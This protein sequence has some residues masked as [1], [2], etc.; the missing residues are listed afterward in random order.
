MLNKNFFGNNAKLDHI[1]I[2]VHS[3]KD[4]LKNN[5]T[6]IYKDK[7]QKVSVVFININGVPIELIEPM[8]SDSPVTMNL[9][10]KQPLVHLC[11][12]VSNIDL[13]IKKSRSFGFHVISKPTPAIAFKN[14]II[15]WLY[16]NIYGLI[17][18][19]EK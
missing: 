14:K 13:A 4:E 7:I 5:K 15:I 6:K 19:V 16:H 8:T 17:E 18:L 10:K 1:G 2:A 11:F 3:I 9:R 12:K